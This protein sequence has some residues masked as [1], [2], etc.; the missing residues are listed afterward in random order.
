MMFQIADIIKIP[1]YFV[2]KV[3]SW[4]LEYKHCLI[5]GLIHGGYLTV[6][7]ETGN[8]ENV[9]SRYFTENGAVKVA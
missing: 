1:T 5:I 6:N 2:Y 3:D 7:L 8:I 9:Y 4:V